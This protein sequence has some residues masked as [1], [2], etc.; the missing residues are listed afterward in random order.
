[1]R[2]TMKKSD[3]VKHFGS[4]RATAEA[5]GVTK[6]AVNNW[7]AV[8]PEAVA[9]R[10]QAITEGALKVDP[11]VYLRLKRKRETAIYGRSR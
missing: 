9:Y 2:D 3:V 11:V 4:N 1:M 5:L 8:V 6:Q 7:G 10:V